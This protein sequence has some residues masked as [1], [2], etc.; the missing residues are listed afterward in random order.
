MKQIFQNYLLILI[1]ISIVFSYENAFTHSSTGKINLQ[2]SPEF[3]DINGGYFRLAKIGQGHITEVGMPELPQFT[4]YYQ[5]DPEKTY[6]FQLE[7]LNSYIIED[8]A[9]MPHQG[10]EKWEVDNVNIINN[11]F[12]NSYTVYPEENMVVSERSQ[13]RGIEFVSINIIPYKYYPK[14]KKLEVYTS[15]DIQ[16]VET[17]DNPNHTLSQPKRSHIFDEFYKDFIIN[18][19]YSDRPDDYQASSIL[20]IGGG[21]WLDNSYVQDLLDW[22]HRQGYIVHAVSTSEIGASSG[23]ENT[24]K[25]YIKDAYEAW[26]NPPEIVGLIGDTDV[27]D[28]FYQDWGTG[29]WNYYNGATDFDYTQLEGND[30]ISDI[31]VGRISGQG[32]SVMEN[33]INKTIQYEKALYVN[34][35]WFMSAALVG[36]PT[37]SGNSTIFTSQ[38]IENIM[39]N[40]GMTGVET[41]YDG[42]GLSNW[43]IDQFQ[44]GILYYNYRGIYG[45][46]GTSPSNQYN[47]GYE[48]PFATVMTCGTGDFDNGNSQ[49]EEFVKMGSV[50]NPEGAVAAVG[51]A[52][53]GTHTA[54]NNIVDMGIYDGI[55]PKK[56]WYA[57]AAEAN[58]D[59]SI[60]ATYPSNPGGA[61]EAFIA[62]SNLIGDPALHL[63][64]G[65]PTNFAVDHIDIISLGT[66]TTDIIVY[67]EGGNTVEGARVTLL[68]GDDVIFTTGLTDEDGQIS[69][70]W[71]AVEAGSMYI[72]VIKQNH[73]PYEGMIE[74]SS[75]SGAAVAL[76]SGPLE[77]ISGEEIDFEITLQN[78]G[79]AIAEDITAE[80][81]SPSEYITFYNN[82]NSFGDIM[83]GASASR[84]FPVYIHE[85]AFHMENLDVTLTIT[86][87][88]GN[89]WINAVPVSVLGPYLIVA[90]Y[91][92]DIFPGS[93]TAVSLN[94]D[95]QG[96]R[97]L[98][99][100]SLELLPYDN[101][102][103][104]HSAMSSISEL[105]VGKN[106]Y[107]DDFELSFSSDIINGTILPV[108]MLLSSSDGFT[109][110]EVINIMVG[111]VRVEDPLGPDPYGYY[112]YDSG[113]TGYELAPDY[114]WIEIAEGLGEQL[115][116]VDYGNGNYSGSYTYS[117]ILLDLPFTFTFYGIDYNQIVV[118]TNGWVSF[119]DFKM[120]SFRN[121]PIPGAGGPSP[122]VAAFWD[123]L[124]TGSGGYIYYY[125]TDDKVVIQWD[126]MRT[127]DGNSRETFEIILYNKELFSS[128]VT[129][130]S[131]IKI[132][133]QEFNNTSDGYYPNGGTPTHGCYSTVGI[134]NSMGDTGLQYTFNN[135]Y[136]EAAARLENGSAIF[137]STGRLPRVNLSLE[138]I[139]LSNGLLDIHVDTDEDIAGFQFELTGITLMGASGGLA[140]GNDFMLSTSSTTV[141]GFSTTG[142][143]VPAG[144]EGILVQVDF[145]E[146]TGDGICFGTDLANNVISNVFGNM[147]DTSWGNCFEGGLAGDVNYDGTLD[148]LDLVAM[149]NLILDSEY[150]SSGDMNQDGQLDILDIV[151][152]VNLILSP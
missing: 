31:F 56:L 3:T 139:D 72:T 111:E 35:D 152:L 74:I 19:E 29:G 94:L 125:E 69:L 104:I 123:D 76:N 151:S 130:D 85:T 93:N 53:T 18:F 87:A 67:D 52:T 106:I 107:L 127:Y 131:E 4:T 108:E 71:E 66:T 129:G 27:I 65:V 51:L 8:I 128:T 110:R 5:L 16:I 13:G 99:S 38:Y 59:L 124:K 78:Y 21:S 101:L 88:A 133:Y 9:V 142:T 146:Y 109:R 28:C 97:D 43:I 77:A 37:Q 57:G 102:I 50:N 63:W 138:N 60:L 112:I 122:M 100:Y 116:L 15:I 45:D 2:H 103:F 114:D 148:I 91:S 6:D 34:D 11:D 83:P 117:S 121:Y 25:N 22:R 61:T 7:V 62:W 10:M 132:Q 126:D 113:D 84:A 143:F 32:Q 115:N 24:I 86:D 96:S 49:S 120:Y 95:N 30:L 92:G 82:N 141:L 145:S 47:N 48:T 54:Y 136:S 149:A 20:Y 70:S 80:L 144:S 90:D 39:I 75:A 68:M 118:N 41:D 137:I 119:G 98:S 147:L 55:F 14:Y 140:E 79:N 26:E 12:Y 46:T 134:E 42:A 40:H 36:D 89:I 23:N 150:L 105:P 1:S 64:S 33:V 73:R 17:G 44:D 135:T 58:G 81:S